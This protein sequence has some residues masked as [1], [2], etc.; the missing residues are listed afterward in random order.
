MFYM[1][2]L[3]ILIYLLF[4]SF[5]LNNLDIINTNESNYLS[6]ITNRNIKEGEE[7]SINY[8]NY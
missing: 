1:K 2:V 7:L 5:K 6:F 3:I 4:K 8:F